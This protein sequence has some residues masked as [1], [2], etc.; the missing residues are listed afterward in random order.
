MEWR[1]RTHT[2]VKLYVVE[3][4]GQPAERRLF[5]WSIVYPVQ[6]LM[7]KAS[8]ARCM[9]GVKWQPLQV[10]HGQQTHEASSTPR[11]AERKEFLDP[12]LS[13]SYRCT[14]SKTKLL[15]NEATGHIYTPMML[16]TVLVG[17]STRYTDKR[18]LLVRPHA[19]C[20]R[21]LR[22]ILSKNRRF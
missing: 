19:G 12:W 5:H 13:S 18:A 9:F 11:R 10:G 1:A 17:V 3:N 16:G 22:P 21:R 15:E 2:L 14:R 7:V 4:L 20:L 8:R 6:W